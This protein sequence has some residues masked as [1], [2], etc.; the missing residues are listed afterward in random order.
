M[1]LKTVYVARKL[2]AKVR[3]RLPGRLR[4]H[5]PILKEATE[6][7]KQHIQLFSDL[8]VLPSGIESV[9]P[10]FITATVLIRYN[11]DQV[12]ERDVLNWIEHLKV[13]AM[14]FIQKFDKMHDEQRAKTITRFID[15][16]DQLE[17]DQIEINHE[18]KI[19][20]H[21]WR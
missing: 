19:P 12:R 8:C 9:A 20:D 11:V 6:E 4:L 3:H 16:I 18:L 5:I 21:V 1:S 17:K 14:Q 13:S 10:N 2:N 7:I 15:F